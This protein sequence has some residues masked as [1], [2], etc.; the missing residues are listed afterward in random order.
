HAAGPVDTD[1]GR[2]FKRDEL[3]RIIA[4]S[5]EANTTIRQSLA[6]FEETLALSGLSIYSLFP[7][8][9]IAADAERSQ[10]SE[11]DPFVPSDQ[12]LGITETWRAGF[13][14]NWEIDLFGSLKSQADAIR[15]R[16]EAD[17]AAY[18]DLQITI[19]AETAQAWF[20]LL[21]AR[22]QAA[23]QAEQLSTLE[24][25]EDLLRVLFDKGRGTQL[26]VARAETE[27]ETLRAQLA[28]ARADVVRQEQRLAVL[29]AWPMATLRAALDPN[30]TIPTLPEFAAAGNPADWLRRR[31]DIRNA[32]RLLAAA[33]SDIGVETAEF[34]PKLELLGGFG[35]TAQSASGI[36]SSGA[37]RWRFGPSI[38]W[39][40]LDYGRIRQRVEA[41][42]AAAAQA[43]AIYDE[44]VLTALEET[45]TALAN[46]RAQ[47]ESEAA[48][49]H[50]SDAASRALNLA[51]LRFQNG[52]D[53]FLD[54]L[55]AQR[56]AL[57][58]QREVVRARTDQAT[59][60]ARLY[61]ALAGG[62]GTT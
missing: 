56:T 55:D 61:K 49:I 6:R 35:W 38:S 50:A 31:P 24:R 30:A 20:A 28:L 36:G 19:V 22:Q 62:F 15:R 14:M 33:T 2:Q 53:S 4:R 47:S 42:D 7:T 16:A 34:F 60:L 27:T 43:L 9:N 40:I 32:E 41:A 37:E 26:D 23:L 59:A 51:E 18:A 25:R 48:L 44:T 57:D 1:P 52:A 54:V 45:E 3:D 46:F 12:A 21:G 13:D 29:T 5:L 8:V 39:R 10:F 58:L 11:Q 17:A